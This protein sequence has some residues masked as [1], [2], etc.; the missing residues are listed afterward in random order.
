MN[1]LSIQSEQGKKAPDVENLTK[2]YR[3]YAQA[4]QKENE[5]QNQMQEKEV[6][7]ESEKGNIQMNNADGTVVI[8]GVE[9]SGSIQTQGNKPSDSYGGQKGDS[10]GSGNK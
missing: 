8:D 2:A 10:G 5:Q 4:Q 6:T 1:R 9:G 7:K 3:N